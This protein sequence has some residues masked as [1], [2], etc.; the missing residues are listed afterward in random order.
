[1]PDTRGGWSIQLHVDANR[2][3]S[4]PPRPDNCLGHLIRLSDASSEMVVGHHSRACASDFWTDL[5]REWSLVSDHGLDLDS[6]P[7]GKTQPHARF[8]ETLSYV[9]ATLVPHQRADCG[10]R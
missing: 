4:Q 5:P 6:N 1:M 10:T 9:H 2:G 7:S 8:S 3:G